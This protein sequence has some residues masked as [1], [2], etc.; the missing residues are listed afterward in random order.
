[1]EGSKVN[2]NVPKLYLIF[3]HMDVESW[4]RLLQTNWN[5]WDQEWGGGVE[6]VSMNFWV[7]LK[8]NSPIFNPDFLLPCAQA[9]KHINLL[10]L[11]S[12]TH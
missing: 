1:M 3:I 4:D 2:S 7:Y 12:V 5:A 10:S 6:S 8:P 9:Q 11:L